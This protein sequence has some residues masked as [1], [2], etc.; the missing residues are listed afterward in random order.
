MTKERVVKNESGFS[1]VELMI[2][3]AIIGILATV[4]IPNFQRF[5]AKARQ[6][7]AKTNLSALYSAEKAFYAEWTQ[8]RSDFRDI[9]VAP[10][11][12]L[13]YHI[14]FTAAEAPLATANP[15]FVAN[16]NGL[17]A[18]LVFNSSVAGGAAVGATFHATLA[19]LGA[20]V[21][22]PVAGPCLAGFNPAGIGSAA[23]FRASAR[24]QPGSTAIADQWSI[25]QAK[26]LCNNVSGI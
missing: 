18:G 26:D 22:S 6:S 10:E 2:V 8:Y 23:T 5:Q 11:G 17:G 19:A 3:V 7:E 21:A 24:G 9:G 13:R 1:L 4:A 20:F 12:M 25:G 14:G 15:Q 16:V